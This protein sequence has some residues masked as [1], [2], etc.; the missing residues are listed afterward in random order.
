MFLFS[1]SIWEF[2]FSFSV[3]DGI[4]VNNRNTYV[5]FIF[6]SNF[7]QFRFS[8]ILNL[9]KYTC[10]SF[11]FQFNLLQFEFVKHLN[12]QSKSLKD[13]QRCFDQISFAW[14]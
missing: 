10:Q 2:K 3:S 6:T 7:M 12:L 9:K 4:S 11:V 5:S 8:T 1:G 14:C 13:F